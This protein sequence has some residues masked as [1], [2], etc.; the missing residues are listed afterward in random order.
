M[1]VGDLPQQG[2]QG[3]RFKVC[4]Q[5]QLEK[6]VP[7]GWSFPQPPDDNDHPRC[8]LEILA[9]GTL[10]KTPIFSYVKWG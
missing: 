9:W 10:L 1:Q 4:F 3:E 7:E 2:L 8:F 5:S 6:S